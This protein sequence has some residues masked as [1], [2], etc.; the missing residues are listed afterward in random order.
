MKIKQIL[1]NN[2]VIAA[3]EDGREII[4]DARGIGFHH[5]PGEEIDGGQYPEMRKYVQDSEEYKTVDRFFQDTDPELIEMAK[6]LLGKESR[7]KHRESPIPITAVMLLADHLNDAARRL[8][9]GVY[10]R[11]AL[12][13]EIKAFYST[14]FALSQSAGT[15]MLEK[16]GVVLN[17][18][19]FAFIAIHLINLNAN[20]MDETMKSIQIVDE[21]VDIVR[22]VMNLELK[23][24]TYIYTRFIT[25]LKYFA[26]RIIRRSSTMSGYDSK[27]EE[28]LKE[29]YKRSYSCALTIRKFILRKYDYEITNDEVIYLTLHLENIN[30]QNMGE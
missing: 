17:E 5:K 19:E 26:E 28:F 10:L 9:N 25:H 2:I 13:N 15:V 12:T 22:R 18:D 14:E 30:K 27:L 4:V 21:L 3:D 20:N 23:I 11:S 7:E 24:N 1:N 16:Y 6:E 8:Q 29:N